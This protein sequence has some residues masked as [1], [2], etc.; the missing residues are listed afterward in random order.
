MKTVPISTGDHSP[1]GDQFLDTLEPHEMDQSSGEKS[2]R[3]K[4][5]QYVI[6]P[7]DKRIQLIIAIQE[8][9]LNCLQASKML[10]IPYINAMIIYRTYKSDNKVI[11]HAKQHKATECYS[12][13]LKEGIFSM[14]K[15]R[16]K[17]TKVLILAIE[18]K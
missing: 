3:G 5:R 12:P 10:S 1:A 2:Q 16:A 18:N 7:N 8:F 13:F 6:V 17:T 11:S 4:K 14:E 15:L 9:R